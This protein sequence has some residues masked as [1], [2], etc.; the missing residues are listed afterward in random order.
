[1]KS[2]F[3]ALLLLSVASPALAETPKYAVAMHGDLKYGPDYKHFDYVNPDAPKGGTLNLSAVGSFDSLNPFVIKGVPAAGFTILGQNF[4]YDSLME[5]STDEPFSM[6]GLVAETIEIADDNSWVAFNLNKAAKW[7]DGVQMTADDV[8]WSFNAL[9]KDGSPF[10]KAYYGD[11]KEVVAESPSRV[12]FTF[13]T[14]E[15]RELPLILSQLTVLPKHYWEAEGRKFGQ[16]TLVPPLGSGPYKI[17]KVAAGRSIEYIRNENYWGKD[18]PVNRGRF[19]FDRINYTYYRD[20]NVSLEAFFGGQFDVTQEN[21]AKSWATAYDA[22]PVKD[23]R[24]IKQEIPNTRP[25]GMQG[26]IYNIR[27]PVFKDPAVREALAHAFDFDW[28]NKQF[29][30]G[31]YTRTKSFFENSPLASKGLPQGRELEILEKYRGKIPESVFTTAYE[32]P[33]SDGSGNNRDNMRIA[34]QI[35]DNAGYKLGKDGIRV[36]EKTGVRL[37][38][39][40]IDSSA[41]FERWTLPFVQNLRKLG[42]QASFRAIDPAQYENRMRDF[43]FDMT[44]M[45]IAQSDS[46][47]NEQRDFWQSVKADTPGS[48]NYI[49]IKDPVVDELIELIINAPDRKELEARTHALDRVLLAGDYVIPHWYFGAWR[50]AWWKKLERPEKLSGLTPGI[51]DTWWAAP[52]STKPAAAKKQ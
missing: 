7:A 27:R 46:P 22:P 41:T 9:M 32:P 21:M 12:K 52:A 2:L 28:S 36:H 31:A 4:L 8:V 50:I 43:D 44:M 20:A 35:L 47:G 49:G 38:F 1:M 39:S 42:V 51:S 34:A 6:Y 3:A 5:Q 48:R 17:G 16:T 24:I 37:T 18:L 11:V 23:G 15:N 26:F 29:A 19:N 33:K 40:I 45:V 14:K 10:Y 30:Y 13:T 25:S